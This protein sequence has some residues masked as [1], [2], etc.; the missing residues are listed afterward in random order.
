MTSEAPAA[1]PAAHSTRAASGEIL[2]AVGAFARRANR[3]DVAAALARLLGGDA[4]LL[5]S[6]DPELGLFLPA[7][8]LRQT[9]RGAAEWR[10]FVERCDREGDA[11]GMLPGPGGEPL[12]A[13]GC[14][15]GGAVAVLTGDGACVRGVAE[16]RPVLPVLGA[17][18]DTERR[19]DAAE[20]RARTADES[21]A[22]ARVLT[23]TLQQVRERLE[24]A[25][26]EAGVARNEARDRAVHAEQLAAEL[27][28]QSEQLQDQAVELEMLNA[29]LSI[30]TEEAERARDTADAANR[31]KSEFLANM[32]HELRT[33]INAIL[34]YGEL[35]DMELAGP[36]TPEQ[37]AQLD[38][39]RSS[40]RHLLTLI[41]D[42]LDL[43]KVEAGQ[44]VVQHVPSQVRVDVLE[45][46]SVVGAQYGERGVELVNECVLGEG[47]YVG[48]PDRV[49]QVLLN[50]LSNAGKFTEAGGRVVVRCGTTTQPD[51]GAYLAGTA[52]WTFVRVEDD[53]IGIGE[54]DAARIFQPFV[55]AREGRTRTQGG[56]GLGL[57]ISRQ[58]AR[59]MGGDLTLQSKPGKGS[60]FTLWLPAD[61]AVQGALDEEIRIRR[62]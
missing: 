60:C 39:I 23:Q 41:N 31:A 53:G 16:L 29:E 6:R 1:A 47:R 7:P 8:G 54:E 50:L 5:F 30:S 12:R 51:R 20:L 26:A 46:V 15:A 25:L 40:S 56:T 19:E 4:L 42:I 35:L 52:N 14:A 58:L 28:A 57:T 37:R 11:S 9:L 32:S 34:G 44:M 55:Q 17:L 38:R 21:A 3:Q 45:A 48:D 13:A 10:A 49:R 43:S 36:V 18:F 33:P 22:R 61:T 62:P 24:E 59:L 2:A 27:Q